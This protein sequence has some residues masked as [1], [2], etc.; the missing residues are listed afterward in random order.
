MFTITK[1]LVK[2][3]LTVQ[4]FNWTLSEVDLIL[5][6]VEDYAKAQLSQIEIPTHNELA[7]M[8]SE[9]G[10]LNFAELGTKL[11][12]F[13]GEYLA[14]NQTAHLADHVKNHLPENF[15]DGV[16]DLKQ[17]IIDEFQIKNTDSWEAL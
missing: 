3:V 2:V 12:A 1:I 10:E 14:E 15:E 5:P 6:G 13:L 8:L 17:L 11:D 16:E 4:L 7:E 9:D